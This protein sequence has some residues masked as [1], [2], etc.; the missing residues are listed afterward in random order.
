MQRVGEVSKKVEIAAG[1][2]IEEKLEVLV[3]KPHLWTADDPYLYSTVNRIVAENGEVLDE[4]VSPLGMRWVGLDETGRFLL[5][6]EPVKLIGTNRHQDFEGLGNALSDQLHE[7]DI[8][9]LK[10]MG[11]NFLRSAHYPHD[12]RVVEAC[13]AYGILLWQEIPLVNRVTVSQ[14]FTDNAC[15]IGAVRCH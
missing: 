13:D 3:K 9:M 4:S 14:A 10:E 12:N 5:N 11:A 1:M 6:G 2:T 7:N 15:S 8:K